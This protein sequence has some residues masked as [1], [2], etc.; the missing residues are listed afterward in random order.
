MCNKLPPLSPECSRGI[1]LIMITLREVFCL[2]I[3]NVCVIVNV[4]GF[5]N[6][7]AC[8]TRVVAV[9]DGHGVVFVNTKVC[10]VLCSRSEHCTFCTS[11]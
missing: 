5:T 2:C 8:Q 3:A 4:C 7:H 11:P 1:A 6:M 10:S 9:A